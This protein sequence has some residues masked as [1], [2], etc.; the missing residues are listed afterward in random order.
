MTIVKDTSTA[1]LYID[2]GRI[3]G[4]TSNM[5]PSLKV[6]A[7][8]TVEI[9]GRNAEPVAGYVSPVSREVSQYEHKYD[10]QG[11]P[12]SDGIRMLDTKV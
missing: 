10:R 8:T 5:E 6:K 7:M 12:V 1:T 4:V 3:V 2:N 9:G 11:N